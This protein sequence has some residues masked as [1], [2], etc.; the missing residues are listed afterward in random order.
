V[1]SVHSLFGTGSMI[2]GSNSGRDK[3]WRRIKRVPEA[4]TPHVKQPGR[5]FDHSPPFGAG[6]NLVGLGFCSPYV[7][8]Y[9]GKRRLCFLGC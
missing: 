1:G 2:R 6:V 9:R 8:Q 5:E 7:S 3:T 4:F